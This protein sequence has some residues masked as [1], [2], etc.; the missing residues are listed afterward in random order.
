MKTL[1]VKDLSVSLKKNGN[2]IVRNLSFSMENGESLIILG[3][4]G[5]GKTMTCSAVMGLLDKKR[6][7]VGGSIQFQGI[8]LLGLPER[9][10]RNYYG[11]RIAFIPQNP[12]T[13]LD[14]SVRIGKQMDEMLKF[15]IGLSAEKRRKRICEVLENSGLKDLD[16]ICR[17]RPHTL[18]GGMLQRV[19][20]AMA[21]STEA[22]FIIADEPTTA[23]DV[24]HRNDIVDSF[25]NLRE[26]GAAL[27]FVTHD[28]TA[29]L[30]LGGNALIMHEGEIIERGS[31]DNLYTSPGTEHT[32]ALV[33]ASA[34]SKGAGRAYS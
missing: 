6:F 8:E 23:L 16:R 29:A 18:S 11:S 28:F 32:K 25:R 34:L 20:I 2:M 33:R 3:Q 15:H 13:A 26:N 10:R 4:S 19:L 22:E 1:E 5:C 24:V 30:R 21:L 17:A 31:I 27:L 9:K 12:M 7:R 14:P